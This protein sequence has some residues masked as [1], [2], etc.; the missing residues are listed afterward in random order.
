MDSSHL[1]NTPT[2]VFYNNTIQKLINDDEHFPQFTGSPSARNGGL[3][4][5]VGF[6]IVLEISDSAASLDD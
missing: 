4:A 2:C 6:P 3:D 1:N 5:I